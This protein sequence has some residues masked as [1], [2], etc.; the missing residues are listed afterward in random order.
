MK[1]KQQKEKLQILKQNKQFS[2]LFEKEIKAYAIRV[3]ASLDSD[4]STA[5]SDAKGLA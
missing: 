2:K 3:Q 1:R 5:G 4:K